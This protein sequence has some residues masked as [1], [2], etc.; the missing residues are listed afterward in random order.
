MAN[1]DS[2]S[3]IYIYAN[4]RA[5]SRIAIKVL[6]RVVDGDETKVATHV[7]LAERPQ[8]VSVNPGH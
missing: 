2:T 3:I 5:F 8:S 4:A 1:A 6:V 7:Y